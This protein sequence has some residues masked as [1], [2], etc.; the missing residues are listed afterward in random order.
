MC[1][2]FRVAW[3][4][5]LSKSLIYI[6]KTITKKKNIVRVSKWSG[7]ERRNDFI[8]R[9]IKK[10]QLMKIITNKKKKQKLN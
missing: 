10:N 8:I 4:I 9:L 5:Q 1:R 6:C 7:S 2:K 3:L